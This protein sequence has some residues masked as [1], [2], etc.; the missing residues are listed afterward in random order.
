MEKF[1]S[2]DISKCKNISTLEEFVSDLSIPWSFYTSKESRQIQFCDFTSP[3]HLTIQIYIKLDH[4]VS[5][6]PKVEGIKWLWDEFSHI[7]TL[8]KTKDNDANEV[9]NRARAWVSKY[10]QVFHAKDVTPNMHVFMNHVNEALGSRTPWMYKQLQ[11]T[12]NGK[13][14]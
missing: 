10:A 2:V 3:E 11:L 12:G 4:L 7:M 8:I 13:V 9:D 1:K 5:W 14:K 6:R